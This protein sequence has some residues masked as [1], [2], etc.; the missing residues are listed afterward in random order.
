M[1]DNARYAYGWFQQHG[2]SPVQAAG[3][4]GNLVQE[5]GVTPGDGTNG[6]D[7][8]R[9]NGIAQWN[10]SRLAGLFDYAKQRGAATPWDLDTQLGYLDWELKNRETG[11]YQ[12]LLGAKTVPDATAAA[13]GYERPQGY[14][15]AN[16]T[17]GNGWA[18]RLAAAQQAFGG[19]PAAAARPMTM[20]DA[21]PH[22]ASAAPM[23][24]PPPDDGSALL[25]AAFA[26]QQPAPPLL[27]SS[28]GP[29][30]DDQQAAMQARRAALLRI[31]V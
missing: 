2:Y 3:L 20:A 1:A 29:Q 23:N 21:L 10:G 11:A 30:Q 4:V 8:G 31:T 18:N 19:A 28:S 6:G 16:P 12:N 22:A 9:S 7:G 17:A 24:V 27:G 13:I 15:A 14:T 26:P 25:A 5:S